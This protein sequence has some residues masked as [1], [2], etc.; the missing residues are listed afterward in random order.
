MA[1]VNTDAARPVLGPDAF[2]EY[3]PAFLDDRTLLFSSDR[4]GSLALYRADLQAG[5]YA[6]VQSDPVA[7]ISGAVDGDSLLYGSYSANGWCVKRTPLAALTAV[8]LE[9]TPGAP[10][11]YPL[12][13]P[14]TGAGVPAQAYIDWPLPLA[15]VPN[16]HRE[17]E[18]PGH[19]RPVGG[20]GGPRHRG[21][22]PWPL[23]GV[24]G[25]RVVHRRLPAPGRLLCFHDGGKRR[26]QRIRQAQLQLRRVLRADP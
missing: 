15:W 10:S 26:A 22:S 5:T 17:P 19:P 14:W 2:G 1:D 21:V 20:R 3:F 9:E 25:C 24:R 23:I 11:P 8:T 13:F 6:L 4:S 16:R 12:P 18:R 7:A